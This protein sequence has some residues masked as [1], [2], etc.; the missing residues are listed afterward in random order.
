MAEGR[1][2]AV[3]DEM[4]RD[5]LSAEVTSDKKCEW[6]DRIDKWISGAR[7]FQ[8]D[9][10]AGAK[11]LKLEHVSLFRTSP[12]ASAAWGSLEKAKKQKITDT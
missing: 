9:Q 7:A 12:E 5:D 11:I 6:D 8:T 1:A 10:R 4:V 2:Y 3:I